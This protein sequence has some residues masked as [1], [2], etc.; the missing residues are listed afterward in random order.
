[1]EIIADLQQGSTISE[2]IYDSTLLIIFHGTD[3]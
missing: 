3:I 2:L 1:L